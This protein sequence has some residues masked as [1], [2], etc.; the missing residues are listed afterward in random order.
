MVEKQHPPVRVCVAPPAQR[1]ALVLHQ[2]RL[3]HGL[4]PGVQV[5]LGVGAEVI[6]SHPSV[7]RLRA[8]HR[9][10]LV[11]KR[12]HAGVS[13]LQVGTGGRVRN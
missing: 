12:T 7:L 8:N 10:L 9:A 1:V 5:L 13:G 2:S 6:R 3:F 4:Q 11:N